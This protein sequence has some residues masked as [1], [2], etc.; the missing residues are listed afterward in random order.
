MYDWKGRFRPHG[1]TWMPEKFFPSLVIEADVENRC[2]S[3]LIISDTVSYIDEKR[4][5][6]LTI[7]FCL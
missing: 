1:N 4:D 2:T 6:K 3:H 5:I 7:D